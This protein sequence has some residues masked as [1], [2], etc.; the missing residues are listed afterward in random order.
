MEYK[1]FS[2]EG[3]KGTWNIFAGMCKGCG[4]CMERCPVDV[5]GWSDE[6]GI[7]ATPIVENQ[8]IEKCTMC[9]MCMNVCP[10]VAI[11]VQRKAKVVK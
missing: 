8:D 10:D 6:L 4:L 7:Y 9:G 3:T 2:R 5:L 1:C 11:L